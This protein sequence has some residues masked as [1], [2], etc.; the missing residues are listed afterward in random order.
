L[1]RGRQKNALGVVIDLVALLPWWAGV[2]LAVASYFFLSSIA[3]VAPAAV[4]SLDEMPT[5]MA[6][7]YVKGLAYVGQFLVPVLW[8][9]A[10]V[11]S[12]IA[13]RRHDGQP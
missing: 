10:A 6:I 13:R 5:L 1:N 3:R 9:V 12:A 2:G 7:S 11:L 8:L 4:K